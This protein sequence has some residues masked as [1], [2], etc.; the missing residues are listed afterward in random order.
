MSSAMLYETIFQNKH[1]KIS[2]FVI[3]KNLFGDIF[4]VVGLLLFC[5]DK[6]KKKRN[7]MTFLKLL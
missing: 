3:Q 6:K 1:N 2:V 4:Q 7:N 5:G